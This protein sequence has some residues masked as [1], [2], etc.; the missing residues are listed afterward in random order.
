MWGFFKAA[1]VTIVRTAILPYLLTKVIVTTVDKDRA[2]TAEIVARAIA[3]QM[4]SEHPGV[5]W[6]HLVDLVIRELGDGLDF[7]PPIKVKRRI[8]EAALHEIG[9][10]PPNAR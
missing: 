5:G 1:A 4:V 10:K 9:V 6:V 2:G 7:D 8:A 3:R